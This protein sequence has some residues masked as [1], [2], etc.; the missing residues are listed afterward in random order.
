MALDVVFKTRPKIGELCNGDAAVLRVGDGRTM[1]A[2]IDALGHGPNAQTVAELARTALDGAPLDRGA[3]ALLELVHEALRGTRGA[4]MTLGLHEHGSRTVELTGV[5]NVS[6]RSLSRSIPFAAM[7][8]VL[9]GR[10]SKPR[11]TAIELE[12]D[13]ALLVTSD[14]IPR[15]VSVKPLANGDP[16]ALCE[17]LMNEAH[18]HDDATVMVVRQRS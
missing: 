7:P 9:G 12:R 17:Q 6:A 5:G 15:R 10:V 1:F 18:A 16:A 4:A 13:E 8:G 2:V 14:G 11:S 3:I